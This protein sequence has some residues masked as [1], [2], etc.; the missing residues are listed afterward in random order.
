MTWESRPGPGHRQ[1]GATEQEDPP[2]CDGGH[3][4]AAEGQGALK[5]A[6]PEALCFGR[7]QRV[8]SSLFSPG[9][10]P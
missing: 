1:D 6:W 8:V 3:A 9:C 4:I 2:P 7:G 10:P 5:G